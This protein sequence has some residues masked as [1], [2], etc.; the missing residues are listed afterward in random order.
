MTF[1]GL[2]LSWDCSSAGAWRS[3]LASA[4]LSSLEQS[5]AYGEALAKVESCGVRR[6]VI[7][8]GG[9][10]LALVQAFEKRRYLPLAAVRIVRGPVWVAQDLDPAVRRDVLGAIKNQFRLARRS[11]LIWSPELP[12]APESRTLMRDCG[13]RQMVTGYST[14][15]LDLGSSVEAL[16]AGLHGK[17]RN[18]L[19]AGEGA[20]LE[21]LISADGRDAEW[22][23]ERCD[24]AR[25]QKGYVGPSGALVRAMAEAAG[26]KDEVLLL[27]AALQSELLAGVLLLRHGG[28]ATY[29]LA[30]SG[31]EG[32]ARRAHNLLLWRAVLELRERGV[33]WLDLG[34]VNAAAPGIARFKLGLHGGL[35]TLIGTWI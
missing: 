17:W 5:W 23:I 2:E 35:K 33:R 28:T 12:A 14:V 20:G 30:W 18:A 6:A 26:P 4:G 1:G 19:L 22:L 13:M 25:R 9:E 32:R 11:L 16:R 31:P 7:Y 27:T 34:G 10:P 24:T 3:L 21:V 15:L 29:L 8:R